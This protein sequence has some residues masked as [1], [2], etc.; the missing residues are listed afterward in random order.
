[1][2]FSSCLYVWRNQVLRSVLSSVID[3]GVLCAGV[4]RGRAIEGTSV[5]WY[6]YHYP[7]RKLYV[8]SFW[9]LL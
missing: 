6:P 7:I 3:A 1:M 4:R 9:E 8:A 5:R 2:A